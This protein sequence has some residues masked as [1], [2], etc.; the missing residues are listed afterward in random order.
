[1]NFLEREAARVAGIKTW[2]P[3]PCPICKDPV[4]A[5][6]RGGGAFA[7]HFFQ[8]SKDCPLH[9][10]RATWGLGHIRSEWDART[11]DSLS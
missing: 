2:F 1:M 10:N 4:V 5:I 8:S 7:K 6:H 11:L 9:D 3:M